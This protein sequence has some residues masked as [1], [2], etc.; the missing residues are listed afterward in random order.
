M[1]AG[2]PVMKRLEFVLTSLNQYC[3]IPS[4]NVGIINIDANLS[5]MLT[6]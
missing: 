3:K 2:K 6:I 4:I 5:G 1:P